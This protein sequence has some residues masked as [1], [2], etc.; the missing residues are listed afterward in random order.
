MKKVIAAVV[1]VASL[2]GRNPAIAEEPM[3]ISEFCRIHSQDNGII[4]YGERKKGLA[5]WLEKEEVI[6]SCTDHG[7]GLLEVYA[8]NKLGSVSVYL[9]PQTNLEVMMFGGDYMYEFEDAN[10]RIY[11]R[12]QFLNTGIARH[13][14][15]VEVKGYY[16]VDLTL[17]NGENTIRIGDINEFN[18]QQVLP[19]SYK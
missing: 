14:D 3:T 5:K 13:V 12:V 4:S 6:F 1:A 16:N 19:D 8:E 10:Q 15:G 9:P 11:A 7:D 2:M 17:K 18:G